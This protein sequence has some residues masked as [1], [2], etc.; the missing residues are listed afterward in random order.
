MII[1]V[2]P[3]NMDTVAI[4]HSKFLVSMMNDILTYL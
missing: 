2:V 4:I 1:C 3:Y